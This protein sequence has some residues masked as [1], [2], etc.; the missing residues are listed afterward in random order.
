MG[1]QVGGGSNGCVDQV[2]G[3]VWSKCVAKVCVMFV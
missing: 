2:C 1:G 3:C